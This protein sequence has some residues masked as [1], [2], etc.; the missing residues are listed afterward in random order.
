MTVHVE[1]EG[2]IRTVTIDR[3]DRRN[4]VDRATAD[5]LLM[6]FEEFAGDDDLRVA[7]LTGAG[8]TFCAGADLQAIAQGDG[9]RVDLDG[10]GPMGPTRLALDKPVLAAIEGF[11]VAGGLELAVWCDLRV[12]AADAVLGVYCRRWGVPLVDGGT[13][14]LPRLI[15]SSHAND[16]ILTGRGVGGD[17]AVRMGLVNRLSEPGA[18]LAVARSLARDLAAL[19]PRCMRSDL[20]SSKDQWDLP[21][22][23]ALAREAELGLATITS[24][25]TLEGAARFAE[26]A[27]RHGEPA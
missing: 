19:P 12:A 23:D 21:M 17:E 13:I 3:P 26:G 15:G 5:A 6:A 7:I 14:R 2:P 20:R 10:P 18:A 1:D 25:E 4:A 27:G 24:G 8:G 9:N 16:L 11:A 22:L